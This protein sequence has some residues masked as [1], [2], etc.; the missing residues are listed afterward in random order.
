MKKQNKMKLVKKPL[1]TI[2]ILTTI[3]FVVAAVS[4]CAKNYKRPPTLSQEQYLNRM[5]NALDAVIEKCHKQPQ[6][7]LIFSANLF[8]AHEVC[9]K[10][11]PLETLKKY[12]DALKEAGVHRVDINMGLFPWLDNH[13]E[14]I[15]KYDALI[16]HI[17]QAK[18]QLAIN[19]Q[20]STMYHKFGKFDDWKTAALEVYPEIAQRYQP[21]IFVVVHEPTVMNGRMGI[22]VSPKEWR[23]FTRQAA[24]AV[25]EVSPGSRCGAGIV[26][27]LE[28][29]RKYFDE[30]LALEELDI[31]TFDIYAINDLYKANRMIVQVKAK[32]KSA[33]I[34]ETWRP[35]YYVPRAGKIETLDVISARGIGN[36]AFQALDA[37]WLDTM[38]LYAGTCG[39]DAVTPFWTQ[40]FF[41]Y[42]K[43]GGNALDPNYNRQVIEAINKGKRTKTFEAFKTI[44]QQKGKNIE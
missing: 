9:I 22:N 31:I 25:K 42:V 17:R 32:G 3:I 6:H 33:Y 18:L 15:Q 21:D 44:I 4:G 43:E 38:A 36:E 1:I 37:K 11:M 14:T 23:D 12:V 19:P 24:M 35:A 29:E 16:R 41:K 13:Q 10:N 34:E 8:F 40:T 7:R 26:V 28:S 20:Y 27:A 2:L 30:F 5:D 39:L